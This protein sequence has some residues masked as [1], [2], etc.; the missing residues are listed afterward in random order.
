LYPTLAEV[1]G[2][3]APRSIDGISYLPTLLGAAQTNR[4]DFLYWEFH[5]RGFQQAVRMGNWKAVLPELGGAMELY[6]LANDLGETK[7]VAAENP[8]VVARI[9]E[10][11]KTARTDSSQWPVQKAKSAAGVEASEPPAK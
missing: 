1:A 10:Y 9:K 2:Q 5:E 6:N 8:E 11:L 3:K 7:D 4:H